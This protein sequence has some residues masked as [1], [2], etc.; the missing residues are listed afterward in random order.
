MYMDS[1]THGAHI[2]LFLIWKYNPG[3]PEKV[4][5]ATFCCQM[6]HFTT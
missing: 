1:L 2:K 5:D 6:Q 3:V 4:T